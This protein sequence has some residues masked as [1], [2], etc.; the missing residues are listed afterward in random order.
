L[1]FEDGRQQA[2]AMNTEQLEKQLV[3]TAKKSPG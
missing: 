2:G 3:A 1:V